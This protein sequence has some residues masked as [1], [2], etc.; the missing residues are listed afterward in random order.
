MVDS[1]LKFYILRT[2]SINLG[3]KPVLLVILPGISAVVKITQHFFTAL[4]PRVSADAK[5]FVL[6]PLYWLLESF[7]SKILSTSHF[8]IL[9]HNLF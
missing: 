2:K 3:T 8:V 9:S 5:D 4:N 7:V 6:F 1:R